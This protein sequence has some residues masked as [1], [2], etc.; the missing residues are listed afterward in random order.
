MMTV[1][2]FSTDERHAATLQFLS[3]VADYLRRWPP[4]ALNREM[5]KRIEDH[6]AEPTHKLALSHRATRS[7]AAWTP[8]GL[9]LV[10]LRL[11]GDV[12]TLKTP[13]KA[14]AQESAVVAALKQGL[15]VQLQLD[16]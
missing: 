2:A 6:L 13:A 16:K 15:S 10:N 14:A 4:H 3:D 11:E 7:G 1:P 8:V 9:C 5:L 12:V